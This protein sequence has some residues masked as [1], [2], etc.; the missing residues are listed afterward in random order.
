MKSIVW[1]SLLPALG[2][3]T[4]QTHILPCNQDSQLNT[5]K[6]PYQNVI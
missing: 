4:G 3:A 1:I 2:A 5:N 6:N